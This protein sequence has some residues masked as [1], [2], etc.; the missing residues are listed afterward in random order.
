MKLR[1]VIGLMSLTLLGGNALAQGQDYRDLPRRDDHFWR[2]K[3]WYR[4]DLEE[5]EN[6]PIKYAEI[7][8]NQ[9]YRKD[10]GVFPQGTEDNAVRTKEGIVFALISAF[11]KGEI[12]TGWVPDS[13]DTP[14]TYAQFENM[15]KALNGN[16][17][18]GGGATEK[19]EEGGDDFGGDDEFDVGGEEE[20]AAE[21]EDVIAGQTQT[22]DFKETFAS[23]NTVIDII[24]DRIF[25]KNKSDMY[26]DLQYVRLHYIDPAGTLRDR[27]VVAFKYQDVMDILEQCQWKNRFNDAEY[28]SLKDILELRLFNSYN[29]SVSGVGVETVEEGEK[30]RQQMLEFEH[31]LWQY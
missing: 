16:T 2:R 21:S 30:R 24:E 31:H 4:I 12:S 26:Y 11:K 20:G 17:G 28:R 10:E 7:G 22:D 1:I 23:L 9:V 29:L 27:A 19:T 18:T 8:L 3:V 13:L 6:R 25:E 5:K 14:L 15:V